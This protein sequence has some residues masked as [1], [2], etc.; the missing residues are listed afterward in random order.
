MLGSF[1]T[2][3]EM[4]STSISWMG[5]NVVI[6]YDV[7][8]LI[9]ICCCCCC[10][11][12][13]GSSD[14]EVR[15]PIIGKAWHVE[16]YLKFSVKDVFQTTILDE[17]NCDLSVT[18]VTFQTSSRSNSLVSVITVHE[19]L[20]LLYASTMRLSDWFPLKKMFIKGERHTESTLLLVSFVPHKELIS[21]F[22]NPLGL[23]L[24]F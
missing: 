11:S 1:K 16:S 2:F 9:F 4:F 3:T 15:Y 20:S 5:V 7:F 10:C 14:K 6:Q 13:T 19:L 23:F 17:F 18:F 12:H 21:Y 8:D 24:V 22:V